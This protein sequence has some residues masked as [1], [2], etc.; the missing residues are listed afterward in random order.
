MLNYL[1]SEK[2]ITHDITG[3]DG[4]FKSSMRSAIEMSQFNLTDSEKEDAIKAITVPNEIIEKA[5]RFGA[6]VKAAAKATK[7]GDQ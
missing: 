6:Y 3:I 2:G 4:D 1:K 7:K 5:F